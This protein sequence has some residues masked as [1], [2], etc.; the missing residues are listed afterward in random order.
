MMEDTNSGEK[1]SSDGYQDYRELY[2]LIMSGLEDQ[3]GKTSLVLPLKYSAEN[4]SGIPVVAFPGIEGTYPL[5]AT[6][7]S[8]LTYTVLCCQY[9][10][11]QQNTIQEI[12]DTLIQVSISFTF[13]IQTNLI[14][15]SGTF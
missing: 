2:D 5:M 7:A 3:D 15:L 6:L 8:R 11:E 10:M 1:K 9:L 4:N 14:T 12:A 13:L